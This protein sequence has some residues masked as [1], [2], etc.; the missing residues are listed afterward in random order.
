MDR[1]IQVLVHWRLL[2]QGK[3]IYI[4]ML[5]TINLR[6]LYNSRVKTYTSLHQFQ[7]A[8]PNTSLTQISNPRGFGSF[9]LT[10][11]L[12]NPYIPRQPQGSLRLVV[13]ASRTPHPS[14]RNLIGVLD[15][16]SNSDSS[17]AP[18]QA[19]PLS[20]VLSLSISV[21]ANLYMCFC[22]LKFDNLWFLVTEEGEHY[23]DWL[24]DRGNFQSLYAQC[25]FCLLRK[26]VGYVIG[27]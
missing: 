21:C 9:S 10:L 6:F 20:L 2:A 24:K 14:P 16:M 1:F 27:I 12:S 19:E 23:S 4:Y 18:A 25:S 3:D 22:A 5:S 17:P 26:N 8:R 15:P 13:D 7:I 11:L